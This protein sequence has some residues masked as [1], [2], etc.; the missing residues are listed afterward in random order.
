MEDYNWR[1]K[2]D[3]KHNFKHIKYFYK[4]K[5]LQ[6]KQ[7]VYSKAYKHFWH[8]LEDGCVSIN[9]S[10]SLFPF[11]KLKFYSQTK[12]TK[13]NRETKNTKLYMS[14]YKTF[15]HTYQHRTNHKQFYSVHTKIAKNIPRF[16]L[17]T[18]KHNYV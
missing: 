2:Y 17:S 14:I 4:H 9:L 8:N 13:L 12:K 15:K 16:P 10:P 1:S 7:I 11:S 5:C 3:T 18:I 6:H